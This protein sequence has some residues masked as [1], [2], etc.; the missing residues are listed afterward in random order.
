MGQVATFSSVIWSSMCHRNSIIST[1]KGSTCTCTCKWYS[2]WQ[3]PCG[4]NIQL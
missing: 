4:G 2:K 1:R 3:S